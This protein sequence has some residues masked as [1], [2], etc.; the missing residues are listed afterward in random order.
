MRKHTS[1]RNKRIKRQRNKG[2]AQK[3]TRLRNCNQRVRYV[4]RITGV[5]KST[6]RRIKKVAKKN[7]VDLEQLLG[8]EICAVSI[9]L[10]T[11]EE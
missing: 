9:F 6:V 10:L 3:K 7:L 1:D 5:S 11:E 4:A 2:L 8:T